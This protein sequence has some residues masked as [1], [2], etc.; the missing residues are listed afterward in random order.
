MRDSQ[1]AQPR[2]ALLATS[3][4]PWPLHRN[5]GAQRT[6]LL[7]Q[8]LH[9]AGCA[10]DIV[11]AIPQPGSELPAAD[12]LLDHGVRAA[13]GVDVTLEARPLP[14][15]P[16]GL[17]SLASLAHVRRLMQ[18]RYAP[19]PV[20]ARWVADHLAEYDLV[21][22]RY[23]Q[24]AL[25]C[26]LDRRNPSEPPPV[27]VDLDDLDWLALASRFGAQPWPGF[28]GRMGMASALGIVKKRSRRAL[29]AFNGLFVTNQPD[30]EA[31]QQLGLDS[32]IL[33]N[34]PYSDPADPDRLA[35]LPPGPED[36]RDVLFIGDLQFGP[37]ATGLDWFLAECWPKVSAG[38]PDA[39]LRIV[40]RGASDEQRAAW[41]KSPG[42]E[43]VGFT[44]DIR[45][46][47]AR[48][49]CTIAPTHWGGGTKI[50]V[51]ES[52]AMGRVCVATPHAAR[53]YEPLTQG[54]AAPVIVAADAAA[55][56]AAIVEMLRSPVRR[57]ERGFSG[58]VLAGRR[59]SFDVLAR[60]IATI[61]PW[62][63]PSLPA[64]ESPPDRPARPANG[65][66]AAC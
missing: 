33:P 59:Y 52:A 43:V 19:N 8:A 46:E 64:L 30:R 39:V 1:N 65:I 15:M 42:V 60:T 66:T 13:F 32:T 63:P 48:C 5:G 6:D 12:E 28:S 23:L 54:P 62:K 22:V 50:K 37:N 31:L 20:V 53:G 27:F 7:R 40:G 61:V 17:K 25:L 24:T 16:R 35:P 36:A 4:L 56:A 14:N 45:S 18:H 26:G 3:V 2:R 10:V 49:A 34:I 58:P 44:L 41:S 29:P 21:V 11:A 47:Y 51:V 9:R 57:A 55:F 38:V